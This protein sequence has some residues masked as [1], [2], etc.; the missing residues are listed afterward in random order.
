MLDI[1]LTYFKAL[2]L[3]IMQKL[4]FFVLAICSERKKKC[5]N[6]SPTSVSEEQEI[7]FRPPSPLLQ[8]IALSEI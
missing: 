5:S 6:Y 4:Y 3:H 8:T 7:P 2:K 1:R